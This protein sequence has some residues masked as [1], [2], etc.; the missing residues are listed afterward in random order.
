MR[1]LILLALVVLFCASNAGADYKE[2]CEQDYN[3]AIEECKTTYNDPS[4]ADQ[5]QE[6]RDQ[7]KSDYDSC[8]SQGADEW[9]S[10]T[11]R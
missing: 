3:T 2:D 9:D 5:L 7:A 8:L 10:D 4:D 1:L 6:C 11:E